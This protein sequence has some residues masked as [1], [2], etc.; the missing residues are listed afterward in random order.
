M[1]GANICGGNQFTVGLN[2]VKAGLGTW[3]RAS[4]L[5]IIK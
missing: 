1:P 4:G 2:K 3:H 5:G